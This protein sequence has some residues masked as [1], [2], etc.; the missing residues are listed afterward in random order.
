MERTISAN[1]LRSAIGE[2]IDA[3]RLHGDRF[4][5]ERGGKPVAVLVPVSEYEPDESRRERIAATMRAVAAQSALSEDEALALALD[6]V[7]A[8]REARKAS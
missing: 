4:I 7:R 2:T 3:V 6:E 5:V 1:E 8:S